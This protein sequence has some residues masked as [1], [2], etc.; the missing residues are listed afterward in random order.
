MVAC[1][2]ILLVTRSKYLIVSGVRLACDDSQMVNLEVRIKSKG[3]FG[4]GVID[5]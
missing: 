3:V 2:V 5:I 4:L 1:S